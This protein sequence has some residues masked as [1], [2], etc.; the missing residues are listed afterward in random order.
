MTRIQIIGVC[1]AILF[2]GAALLFMFS[3][4][5]VPAPVVQIMPNVELDK[6]LIAKNDLPYGLALSDADTEWI[7][8][9]RAIIPQ[10]VISQSSSPNAREEFRNA[11]VLIP[12]SKGDPIR[13]ERLAKGVSAGVMATML[14]SGKRAVAVDVAVNTT[15]GGFILP[16]D[17]VDV[18]RIFRDGASSSEMGR[19]VYST[20]LV[21]PNMR[22]LAIGQTIE[23]RNNEAVVIGSTATLEVDPKQAEA[24][25]IAQK[26]G[27]LVLVL[28]SIR[29][30]NP[31]GPAEEA[32]V[33]PPQEDSLTIVK[34]GIPTTMRAK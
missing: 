14:P 28:R 23:K 34:Y 15:A 7:D 4:S 31:K 17:R 2:G 32:P 33:K 22:V 6:V 11:H 24:L 1:V 5:S 21:L 25:L 29:D 18:T 27:Q 30:A 19:D 8:W 26:T 16:N 13:A 9:P 20:E 12:T 10:G 3:P